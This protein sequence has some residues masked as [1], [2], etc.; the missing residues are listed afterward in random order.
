MRGGTTTASGHSRR[1]CVPP[2][3]PEIP[4]AFASYDA[5]STTPPPTIT[6][7]PRSRGSSRCST[8]A[9]N[10]SRSAC[11]MFAAPATNICSHVGS[12]PVVE[13]FHGERDRLVHGEAASLLASLLERRVV[14]LGADQLHRLLVDLRNPPLHYHAELLEEGR[15][16]GEEPRGLAG[17]ACERERSREAADEDG[18]LVAVG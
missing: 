6:G 8:D 5:A 7:R 10:A 9:K 18:D 4:N 17:P 12:S 3:P 2:I 15:R 14:Q 13:S 1:A 16:A 11:R